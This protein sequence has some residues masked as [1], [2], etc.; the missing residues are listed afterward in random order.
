MV[1]RRWAITRAVFPSIASNIA[2]CIY[3]SD[4]L[5][6]A[7]VASSKTMIGVSAMSARAIATRCRSHPESL[8]PLSQ[9]RVLYHLG[10][11]FINVSQ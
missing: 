3:C 5:S 9:T 11:L 10:S 7:D 8:I 2:C 1:E 6:R 4:S